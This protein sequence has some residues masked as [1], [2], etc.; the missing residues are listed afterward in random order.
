MFIHV[1]AVS[2]TELNVQTILD[3]LDFVAT[4]NQIYPD[5]NFYH[6]SKF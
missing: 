1:F 2:T 4:A 5:N 3:G 6:T